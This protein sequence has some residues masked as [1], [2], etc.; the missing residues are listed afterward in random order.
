[1]SSE[2]AAV[3]SPDRTEPLDSEPP[4]GLRLAVSLSAAAGVT[5]GASWWCI[6]DLLNALFP[7]L[8][9]PAPVARFLNHP[10]AFRLLG[11]PEA[12]QRAI[13]LAVVGG[14]GCTAFG[15]AGAVAARRR[16]SL[17]Q[18]VLVSLL[19]GH[20]YGIAAGVIGIA[21]DY[22]IWTL[23]IALNEQLDAVALWHMHRGMLVHAVSWTVLG[24]GIGI[25]TGFAWGSRAMIRRGLGGAVTGAVVAAVLYPLIGGALFPLEQTDTSIP[26]GGWNQLLWVALPIVLIAAGL[27][28]NL[29]NSGVRKRKLVSSPSP[30]H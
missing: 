8:H 4:N 24:V 25:S 3:S 9:L 29:S 1:M 18:V 23:H 27:T 6:A 20:L 10:V 13:C 5:I 11:S 22:L 7:S 28:R 17:M 26:T 16:A 21:I 2:S 14:I 15:A 19:L 12:L 30:S